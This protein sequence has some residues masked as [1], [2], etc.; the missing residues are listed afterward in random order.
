MIP[1]AKS[2]I[3]KATGKATPRPGFMLGTNDRLIFKLCALESLLANTYGEALENFLNL[4]G[5]LIDSY[6]GHCSDMVTE[7]REL[8]ESVNE[9][10][11]AGRLTAP[12]G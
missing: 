5:D 2:N 11:L 10:A 3:A 4:R 6:L 8:A 12:G 1:A 9:Q 7:C